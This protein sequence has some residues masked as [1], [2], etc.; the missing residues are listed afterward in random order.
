M[1]REDE[2]VRGYR[3][4]SVPVGRR[5][6]SPLQPRSKESSRRFLPPW[7][8]AW[9]AKRLVVGSFILSRTQ[10]VKT[11]NHTLGFNLSFQT[12]E[13]KSPIVLAGNELWEAAP[14][15]VRDCAPAL[16]GR[17][18]AAKSQNV[19]AAVFLRRIYLE[20]PVDFPA[21]SVYPLLLL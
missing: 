7:H 19:G 15:C 11:F 5:T 10:I 3:L 20:R 9:C 8:K 6:Y 14:R 12:I 21:A 17:M 1:G 4:A 13:N 18:A 16:Q 2:P